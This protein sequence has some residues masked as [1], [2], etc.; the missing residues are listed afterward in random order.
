M[1]KVAALEII[2]IE[3]NV[4]RKLTKI[5]NIRVYTDT[6]IVY[7][8]SVT[9]WSHHSQLPRTVQRQVIRPVRGCELVCGLGTGQRYNWLRDGW[10]NTSSLDL[11]VSITHWGSEGIRPGQVSNPSLDT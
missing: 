9:Q 7:Y 11:L 10:T 8:G 3:I 6:D 1:F 2:R 4:N 5:C